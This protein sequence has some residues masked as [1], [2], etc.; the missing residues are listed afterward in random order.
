MLLTTGQAEEG[1]SAASGKRVCMRANIT[2]NACSNL[3]FF[4][5]FEYS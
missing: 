2:V 5:F 4:F 1:V 3:L